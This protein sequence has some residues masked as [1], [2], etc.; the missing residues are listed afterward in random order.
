MVK[1]ETDQR[2][3]VFQRLQDLNI[4]CQCQMYG[5]LHVQVNDGVTALQVWQV[6]RQFSASKQDLVDWLERCWN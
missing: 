5:D 6:L 4:P 3:L 1:V 2:W